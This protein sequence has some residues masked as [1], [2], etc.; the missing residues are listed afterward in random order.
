MEPFQYQRHRVMDN[1][2]KDSQTYRYNPTNMSSQ[3]LTPNNLSSSIHTTQNTPTN[4]NRDEDSNLFSITRERT[5]EI[6]TPRGTQRITTVPD[7]YPSG[8]SETSNNTNAPSVTTPQTPPMRSTPNTMPQTT[9]MMPSQSTTPQ[10]VPMM[11]QRN[12]TS[13]MAPVMPSQ[14]TTPQTAPVTPQRNA[15]S[16]TAPVMPQRN[17]STPMAPVMPSQSTTSPTAPMM[18]Q[19][20]ATSPTAPV[21]PQRNATSPMAPIMPSQSTTSPTAPMIPSQNTTSPTAPMM[22]QRNATSPTAPMM[23]SQ[24]ATP[25]VVPMMPQ[26]N[27]T[28]PATPMMPSQ[29]AT[30]PVVPMMPQRNATSPAAS[31]QET[32][33]TSLSTEVPRP[34]LD[35]QTIISIPPASPLKRFDTLEECEIAYEKDL[36]YLSHLNS[37][38]LNLLLVEIK[39]EFDLVDY[40][41][42][43][44]F[45]EFPDRNTL[46]KMAEII[47]ER[48]KDMNIED[49]TVEATQFNKNDKKTRDPWLQY[50]IETLMFYELLERRRHKRRHGSRRREHRNF[51]H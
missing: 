20:N 26:R 18:P 3:I 22:P 28:S 39:K 12:A 46:L 36:K 19:R 9:P 2:R 34:R 25:S 45:D 17:A 11:P 6:A 42:S 27:A 43:F 7:I 4:N 30:P 48:A 35:N 51:R 8:N 47:L 41:G 49:V 44:I 10:T 37:A 1:S 21:T 23:P 5:Q 16:P 14:S 40:D 32:N 24:N 15:T 50:L 38:V 31:S 13:P 29:N 33:Q